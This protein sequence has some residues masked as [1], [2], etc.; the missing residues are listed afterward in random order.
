MLGPIRLAQRCKCALCAPSRRLGVPPMWIIDRCERWQEPANSLGP[1]IALRSS[2]DGVVGQV[3]LREEPFADLYRDAV[4]TV[5]ITIK[6]HC[7]GGVDQ[8]HFP[9]PVQ[10]H[11]CHEHRYRLIGRQPIS[12]RDIRIEEC[13]LVQGWIIGEQDAR[14]TPSGRHGADFTVNPWRARK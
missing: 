12:K 14:P 11:E 4:L 2:V 1:P 3:A 6:P 8:V 10:D 5:E 9:A 13:W 7:L